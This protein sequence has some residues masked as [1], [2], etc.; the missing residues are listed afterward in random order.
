MVH[1]LVVTSGGDVKFKQDRFIA[2]WSGPLSLAIAT[3]RLPLVL[4]LL[5]LFF[6]FTD[7]ASFEKRLFLSHFSWIFLLCKSIL[8]LERLRECLCLTVLCIPFIFFLIQVHVAL[9]SLYNI[10]LYNSVFNSVLFLFKWCVSMLTAFITSFNI[11]LDPFFN[12]DLQDLCKCSLLAHKDK[13]NLIMNPYG[14]LLW[15]L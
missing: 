5:R 10:A 13:L 11:F 1:L 15:F 12:I 6:F 7:I 4:F 8:S 9:N 14:C 3:L 2:F